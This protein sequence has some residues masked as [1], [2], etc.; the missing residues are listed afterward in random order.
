MPTAFQKVMDYTLVG[1]EKTHFFLDD[2]IIVSR[3]SKDDHLKFAYNCLKKLDEE[4][5]RINL[6]KCHFAKTEIEWLGY[7]VAFAS[8]FLN[9]N[10]E[11][12]SIKIL[13]LLGVVWSVESF[14]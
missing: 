1:I 3:G 9:S 4:N 12:Y 10:E 8:R 13:E 14:E 5:L 2:I 6:P 11:R 7:I